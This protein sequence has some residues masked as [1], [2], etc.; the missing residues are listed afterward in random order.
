LS[1]AERPPDDLDDGYVVDITRLGVIDSDSGDR[2][3][4]AMSDQLLRARAFERLMRWQRMRHELMEPIEI[5]T[6]A[7][8]V[9]DRAIDL[10]P[11]SASAARPARRP[12]A[13]R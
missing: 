12:K 3:H 7:D 2:F 8:E 10:R 4:R 13:P 11:I 5:G 1:V 9:L 6:P